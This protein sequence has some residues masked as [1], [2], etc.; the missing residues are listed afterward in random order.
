MLIL[1]SRGWGEGLQCKT[2]PF[3]KHNERSH[4]TACCGDSGMEPYGT[5]L[6][7]TQVSRGSTFLPPH[8][9]LYSL[10]ARASQT[11]PAL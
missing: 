10:R 2:E 4:G 9:I 7:C 11:I 5:F 6:L 8:Q 3:S 1:C